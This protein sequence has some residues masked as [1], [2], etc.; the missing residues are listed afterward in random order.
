MD[1]DGGTLADAQREHK[2][3][4]KNGRMIGKVY[5]IIF[6]ESARATTRI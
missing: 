2:N 3:P 5:V 4:L 6:L 1:S